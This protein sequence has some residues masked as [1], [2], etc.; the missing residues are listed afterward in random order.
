MPQRLLRDGILD[1]RAVQA[2]SDSAMLLY[3]RLISVV[4]DYGR[5]DLD[6]YVIRARCFQFVFDRWPIERI[7]ECMEELSK[8]IVPPNKQPLI[9]TYELDGRRYF[10]VNKF[11]QR[12]QARPRFPGPP[13]ATRNGTGKRESTPTGE[14]SPRFEEWWAIWSAI[15]GTARHKPAEHAWVSVVTTRNFEDCMECT[16]SYLASLDQPNKG[17]NP[18]TFLF[19]QAKEN[20][21]PRW[22]QKPETKRKT[23]LERAMEDEAK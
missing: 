16:R 21:A 23:P 7:E 22:P 14:E 18:D 9:T 12:T 17:F 13:G 19:E 20:F 6:C 5:F 2:V 11:N 3:Y 10:Q 8:K 4:D 1:S 15:R